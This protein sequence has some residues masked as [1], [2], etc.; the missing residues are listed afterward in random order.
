MD[1]DCFK[2][3]DLKMVSGRLRLNIPECVQSQR[4]FKPKSDSKAFD[5]SQWESIL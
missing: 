4:V 5:M 1:K 2:L 3:R